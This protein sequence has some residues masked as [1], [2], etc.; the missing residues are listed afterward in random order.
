MY[1]LRTDG[2]PIVTPQDRLGTGGSSAAF[3][4]DGVGSTMGYVR[5][6]CVGI[7]I[8]AQRTLVASYI[9]I[10]ETL[11]TWLCRFV[12]RLTSKTG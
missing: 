2:D 7:A 9:Y 5:E 4:T 11:A 3:D 12:A 8:V 6:A 1:N 10:P